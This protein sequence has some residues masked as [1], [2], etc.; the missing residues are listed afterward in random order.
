MTTTQPGTNKIKVANPPLENNVRTYLGADVSATGTALTVASTTG[1]PATTAADYYVIIEDYGDERA[2][3]V[4]VDASAKTSTGLTVSALKYPHSASAPVTYIGY[5]KIM[6]YGMETEAGT[7][8]AL[9]AT[10]VDI[11]VTEQY[12]EYTYSA[13]PA[14][15]QY[16]CSAYYNSGSDIISGYSDVI[17]TETFTRYSAKKVIE[18]ATIKAMTRID[19][20]PDSVLNWDN[21]IGILQDGIDEILSAKRKWPF[22]KKIDS[23]TT[24]T[25]NVAYVSKPSDMAQPIYIKVNNVTMEWLDPFD[26]SRY[27][28]EDTVTTG[29]PRFFTER[30]NKFYFWPTPDSAYTIIYDYY[31]NPSTLTSLSTEVDVPFL[32]PLIY[33]C[34]AQFAF[35]RG[36]DK[37]GDKMME[38]FDQLLQQQIVEY[39]GPKQDGHAEYALHTTPLDDEF[40]M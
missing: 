4:L 21:A 7:K 6:F 18:S 24:T 3:I 14:L 31:K 15:Y 11:D 10:G 12:T 9:V 38:R 40:L 26:Y 5:N 36:N 35:A 34:A 16:F 32:T 29:E 22:L 33:Y 37:R 8:N 19:D 2:E 1:F 27:T 25:A 13:T 17:H 23:S 28:E 20:N 30:E 39:S